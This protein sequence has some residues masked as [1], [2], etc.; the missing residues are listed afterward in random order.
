M[1]IELE[2]P[3]VGLLLASSPVYS[4]HSGYFWWTV[5][6]IYLNSADGLTSQIVHHLVNTHLVSEVFAVA[7]FR[8]MLPGHPVH[9]LLMPHFQGLVGVNTKGFDLLTSPNG[10]ITRVAGFGHSGLLELIRSA[11][12]DWKFDKMNFTL[13]LQVS[14]L[15]R[16]A[17]TFGV[18]SMNRT[19]TTANLSS[20]T[21]LQ[22]R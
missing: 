5:A 17:H 3:L 22:R 19:T 16:E 18:N 21:F 2:W 8:N 6:K 9:D 11:Y 14:K 7:A 12:A 4:P 20:V 13:D 1:P 15:Y 10:T